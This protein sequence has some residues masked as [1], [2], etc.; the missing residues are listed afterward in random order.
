MIGVRRG[1]DGHMLVGNRLTKETHYYA[2]GK[3]LARIL[4]INV[5]KSAATSRS[6]LGKIKSQLYKLQEREGNIDFIT[7]QLM[8]T[9]LMT[10]CTT[11]GE[12]W[13]QEANQLCLAKVIFSSIYRIQRKLIS[14]AYGNLLRDSKVSFN[15]SSSL[16][17]NKEAASETRKP[18]IEQ[19]NDRKR[20][21][22]VADRCRT[23][24]TH[25]NLTHKHIPIPQTMKIPDAKA[26][27]DK[28]REKLQ[29]FPACNEAKVKRKAVLIQEA[30]NE[31]K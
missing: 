29:Q 12:S 27:V 20:Q 17:G 5:K 13:N 16:H 10:P 21:D 28:Y 8:I 2:T 25:Y 31:G 26:A 14:N 23:S 1:L 7:F 11:Q 9:S 30:K 3:H 24:M 6:R 4:V 18:H 22:H 15:T 19:S